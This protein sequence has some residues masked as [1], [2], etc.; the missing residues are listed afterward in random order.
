M[1]ENTETSKVGSDVNRRKQSR[2]R[3][4]T[5]SGR[6]R[7]SRVGDQTRSQAVSVSNG[8]F[9]NSYKKVSFLLA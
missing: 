7:G 5:N 9:E 1:A 8:Q 6:G 3:G 2:S 4:Q